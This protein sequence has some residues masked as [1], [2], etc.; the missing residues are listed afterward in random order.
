MVAS[1]ALITAICAIA[2]RAEVKNPDTFV[3][4][5]PSDLDG[6]DPAWVYDT[7][8]H[9]VIGNV[10]EYLV[11]FKGA[12][13]RELEPRLASKVPSTSNGLISKDGRSYFFPIRAGVKFHDGHPLTPE[14]VKYSLMRFLLQD[15]AGG[16]SSLL[17]EP[18]LGVSS[19]R[20]EQGKLLAGIYQKADRAVEVRKDRVI[21]HLAKPFAP[22]LKILANFGAVLSKPWCV[23]QGDWDGSE[24]GL[25]AFNN[26][27]RAQDP[28][29]DKMNGTG[30]FR[31]ERWERR[32]REIVLERNDNYWREPA[33]LKRV[34]IRGVDEFAT[35]KLMLES[36]DADS[37]YAG[38]ASFAQLQNLPG[39]QIVDRL[40]L[41]EAPEMLDFTFH[42]NPTGNPYIGSGRLDGNGIPPDFFT[43]K[44]VRLGFA[45]IVDYESLIRDIMR[46]KGWRTASVVPK[47]LFQRQPDLP[48]RPFDLEKAKQHFKKAWGGKVW[49]NGF[50][51]SIVFIAGNNGPKTLGTMFK[52]NIE[53]L[54]PKFKLDIR[55][56]QNSTFLAQN[57]QR[58]I[59]LFIGL[60][61]ADYPDPHNFVFPLLHSSGYMP[62]KQGYKNPEIDRLIEEAASTMNP[63]K[64]ES[65]YARILKLANDDLPFII[66]FDGYRYRAQ[67]SWVKGWVF[68][69]VFPE[70]PYGDYYY[71]I[72]KQER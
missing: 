3:Y 2:P 47:S 71:S 70:A 45:Y 64:R 31:L 21:I 60:W 62:S 11:A 50:E 37:I 52:R 65:L 4:A 17:L 57:Q 20:D 56:V 9:L 22:F 35:R 48:L 38:M 53:S 23:A 29:L 63:G 43:D 15:R 27:D 30:P 12:S 40:E 14:D 8:S 67:R 49:E 42:M 33:K 68:N 19:T 46:G 66:A 5:G 6:L 26:R 59:P 54:N 69:P 32:N 10:Y 25:A 36:G 24:K 18:I 44:D 55:E 51:C 13:I 34:I 28:L 7:A 72:Y 1:A 41:L 58:Q 16:P 61:Q 39:V